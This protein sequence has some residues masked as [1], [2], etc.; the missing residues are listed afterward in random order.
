MSKKYKFSLSEV[1][2]GSHSKNSL[3]YQGKAF[4]INY[5]N[6]K[7]VTSATAEVKQ[8]IQDAKKLGFIVNEEYNKHHLHLQWGSNSKPKN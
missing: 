5:I 6:G 2:G 4:D 1:A 8:F 7:H 3:H